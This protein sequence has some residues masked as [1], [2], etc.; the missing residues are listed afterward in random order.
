M[1]SRKS[2]VTTIETHEVWV[3]RKPQE[4]I[5]SF[6]SDCGGEARMIEPAEAAKL[7]RVS[8]RMI[9]RWVE[10]GRVHFI[11]TPDGRLFICFDSLPS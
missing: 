5:L 7:A 9:Y 2:I 3:I 6:C 8:M 11:E 1:K 10:E 4:T